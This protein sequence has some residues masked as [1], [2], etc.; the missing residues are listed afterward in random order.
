MPKKILLADD[1]LTIQKVVE[2]TLSG[3]DY[4]LTCVSNGQK[5]L[6]SL[7]HSRPDLIL[8]DV[9]MPEM[10][11]HELALRLLVSDDEEEAARLIEELDVVHERRRELTSA[12]LA[13]ARALADGHAGAQGHQPVHERRTVVRGQARLRSRQVHRRRSQIR[14]ATVEYSPFGAE[15]H[16]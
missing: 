2:L 11:G 5:A 10:N 15:R 13:E 14:Y 16:G 4:E 6:A 3:T 9:V 8:A 12:A 7:E 1:S